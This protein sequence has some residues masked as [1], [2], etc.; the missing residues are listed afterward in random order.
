MV[1]SSSTVDVA[2]ASEAEVPRFVTL[3]HAFH[4]ETVDAIIASTRRR[5]VGKESSAVSGATTSAAGAESS[6]STKPLEELDPWRVVWA[7]ATLV[8]T[9]VAP[10]VAAANENDRVH[11]SEDGD[12]DTQAPPETTAPS[13]PRI[14]APYHHGYFI[15]NVVGIFIAMFAVGAAW[16]F[17]L[18]GMLLYLA[19]A[20]LHRIGEII[21]LRFLFFFIVKVLL[22]VDALLLAISVGVTELL[23]GLT[24]C[25][26]AL[27]AGVRQGREW[28]Q[29]I[30]KL[31]TL[32]RWLVRSQHS[33]W[34]P[35][36]IFPFC[37]VHGDTTDS[38]GQN[39]TAQRRRNA[40]RSTSTPGQLVPQLVIWE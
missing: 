7:E 9:D 10:V 31:C 18:H 5:H 32:A 16:L 8:S 23:A 12:D 26:V 3:R 2:E 37:R 35:P 36:R 39:G 22:S 40:S 17:E 13:L 28:Y 33:K 27:S 14:E 38:V 29:Y 25:L 24:A 19:A 30:R 4:P 15:D 34:E 1:S 11:N 21:G 20:L 6:S